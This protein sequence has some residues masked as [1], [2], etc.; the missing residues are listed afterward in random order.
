VSLAFGAAL[1]LKTTQAQQQPPPP[2][3]QPP[4]G[5]PPAGQAGQAGPGGGRGGGRGNNAGAMLFTAMCSG[6]HGTP[7]LTGRAPWL[8]DQKWLDGT[9][10]AKITTTVR[11]GVPEKG[12]VGFLPEQLTDEQ[13]F[14]LIAYVR[15]ATAN[16]KP[17]PAYVADPEGQVITSE[18]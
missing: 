3:G 1:F 9:D 13:I 17:R 14:Q 5:T 11:R 10:D 18:K 7:D 6:C 2:A 16:L 12:M 4:V 15:T 8:F